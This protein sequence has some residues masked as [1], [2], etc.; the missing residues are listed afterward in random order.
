MTFSARSSSARLLVPLLLTFASNAALAR[1]SIVGSSA[2]IQCR[3]ALQMAKAAFD[4]RSF[5]LHWPIPT[6]TPPARIILRQR[7]ADISGGNGIEADS[8]E[9][10][11][12]HQPEGKDYTPTVFW[13]RQAFAGKRLVIVDEPFNW[14][15][16]RYTTYLVGSNETPELLTRELAASEANRPTALKPLLG[17]N[18]WNPPTVLTSG[19]GSPYWIIDRGEPYEVMPDWRV[20]VPTARAAHSPCEISFG[21]NGKSGLAHMPAAVRKLAAELDQALGPGTG[22]GTLQQTAAIRVTVAQAWANAAIRPWALT[23]EPYNSRAEVERGLADWAKSSRSRARLLGRI[24]HDYPV[25]QRALATYYATHSSQRP[26][27]TTAA[28]VLDYMFRT[29]FVFSKAGTA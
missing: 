2:D 26:A 12:L 29:Y 13:S 19:T 7:E 17:D 6:P 14:R 22:E 28:R 16:D 18:R 8:S 3:V 23:A 5:S 27:H 4:G 9:F 21:M 24:K 10:L 11:T 15:G 1:P 20:F 25:A